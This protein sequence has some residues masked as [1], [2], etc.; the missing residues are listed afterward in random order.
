ML[1]NKWV[2]RYRHLLVLIGLLQFF[3]AAGFANELEFLPRDFLI[4]FYT[5]SDLARSRRGEINLD[6]VVTQ[7]A[8]S[9]LNVKIT[10]I[11]SWYALSKAQL[12]QLLEDREALTRWLL[13][14]IDDSNLHSLMELRQAIGASFDPSKAYVA[15]FLARVMVMNA[16]C[17]AAE[18]AAVE[19]A[20]RAALKAAGGKVYKW[21]PS[22]SAE[23]A[24][25]NAAGHSAA[26]IATKAAWTA[27]RDAAWNA[28]GDVAWSSGSKAAV[29]EGFKLGIYH[30]ARYD[31]MAVKNALR[32]L[33]KP[34][35][36]GQKAYPLSELF[37]LNWLKN[38][39]PKH[40]TVDT[41]FKCI[42]EVA[43]HA[44]DGAVKIVQANKII[45]G[46]FNKAELLQ[47]PFVIQF[48]TFLKMSEEQLSSG[49]EFSINAQ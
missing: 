30:F 14:K 42:L 23:M 29:S 21:Y 20:R 2:R 34:K 3:C 43:Y 1:L 24:A 46:C 47:N 35:I 9:Y 10:E 33:N 28:A 44:L 8:V 27:A 40:C 36:I 6:K 22:G 45:N 5:L 48:K 12:E 16:G 49:A 32:K 38:A 31:A 15:S 37:V 4:R 19:A 11:D 13:L 17:Q 18:E 41:Y 25:W 39:G 26:N 7:R